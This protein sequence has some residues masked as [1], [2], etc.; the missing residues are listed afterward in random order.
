MSLGEWGAGYI[1]TVESITFY[2]PPRGAATG[3]VRYKPPR[4]AAERCELHTKDTWNHV[5]CEKQWRDSFRWGWTTQH[6]QD[7]VVSLWDVV[8]QMEQL[9]DEDD[10]MALAMELTKTDERNNPDTLKI[11]RKKTKKK[12][13]LDNIEQFEF[14]GNVGEDEIKNRMHKSKDKISYH[15]MYHLCKNHANLFSDRSSLW[16]KQVA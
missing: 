3:C 1:M 7:E 12:L 10:V 13:I 11:Q 2:K 5:W 8:E 16:R 4:G 14:R 9:S 6:A 15:L